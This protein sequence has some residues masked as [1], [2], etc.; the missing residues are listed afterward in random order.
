MAKGPTFTETPERT[1]LDCVEWLAALWDLFESPPRGANPSLALLIRT[2][3][4]LASQPAA[5]R[6]AQERQRTTR[7]HII[8]NVVDA[9]YGSS[10]ESRDTYDALR[11]LVQ[12][13]P[14]VIGPEIAGQVDGARE[15]AASRVHRLAGVLD[16][17]ADLAEVTGELLPLEV[18][19]APSVFLPSP[20]AGRH[21]VLV[22]HDG[23]WIAHLHFGFALNRSPSSFTV[24]REW[25]LG[26]AWHYAI[27]LYLR[28]HWPGVVA[29]LAEC[30]L[31]EPISRI[32]GERRGREP[33]AKFLKAHVSVAMK[34]LLSRRAGVPDA[35]HRAVAAASGLVL[36]PW[37]L[38]WLGDTDVRGA[39][40][41][42]H[43]A[44]LPEAMAAGR[45]AWEAMLEPGAVIAPPTVN[46][47]LISVAA[48]KAQIVVPD[49][50]S[51][52]VAR[53]AVSKWR[54]L[55]LPTTRYSEWLK[56][57]VAGA[58]VIA[59]GEPTLN[60]LVRL[61]LEQRG[62]DLGVQ[63]GGERA[64]V[65]I[66]RPGFTEALWCVAVAVR[67]PEAAAQID[68]ETVLKQTSSYLS[69]EGGVLVDR[70]RAT[71]RTLSNVGLEGSL[72]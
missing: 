3:P 66:S 67:R 30:A 47:A 28:P 26:G 8:K 60:P 11:A 65:A 41:T 24:S 40:M 33:W 51:D 44:S 36:F 38:R 42:A 53:V 21:G 4:A 37:F 58:P 14:A 1:A 27:E 6:V 5:V 72:A 31:A 9:A 34:C 13:A 46:L 69:Y 64:I 32:M 59:F 12:A 23:R 52:E 71:I 63:A 43:L 62:L 39:K 19:L 49:E 70:D 25:L 7:D 61:V 22:P 48:R 45:A 2:P 54:I 68:V 56:A 55:S 16:P 50:W 18:V 35:I 15:E 10:V 20:Q 57:R 17:A 29:R